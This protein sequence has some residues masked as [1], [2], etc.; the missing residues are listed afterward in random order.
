MTLTQ[1]QLREH[2]ARRLLRAR[3]DLAEHHAGEDPAALL[4]RRAALTAES[5]GP[6]DGDDVYAV[7]VLRGLSLRPFI[8]HA[9]SFAAALDPRDAA[10]WRAA[11]SR[12]VFLAGNPLALGARFD[13]AH[14]ASDGSAAWFGPYPAARCLPLRRLLKPFAAASPAAAVLPAGPVTVALPGSAA[15]TGTH[16]DLFLVTAGLTVV[17]ALIHLNHLIAEAAL[18]GLLAPGDTVTLRQ[19]PRLV[20]LRSRPAALRV[21]VD[22]AVPARLQAFAALTQEIPHA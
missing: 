13:F 16:R 14:V 21:D 7:A 12:T 17:Q 5:G 19:V 20:G 18:D 10:D 9:W 1:E 3:P 6:A 11:F 2:A 4:A 15:R 8:R 22:P